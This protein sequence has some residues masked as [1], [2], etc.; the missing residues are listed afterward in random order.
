MEKN[1]PLLK[2]GLV[3]VVK[4][5]VRSNEKMMKYFSSRRQPE[6]EQEEEE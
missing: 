5:Y 1:N 2:K 3:K 6:E 4:E